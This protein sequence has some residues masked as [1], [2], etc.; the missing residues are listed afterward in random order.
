M[1]DEVSHST[2]H[3]TR[4]ILR[5]LSLTREKYE[6]VWRLCAHDEAMSE[7]TVLA[8][9]IT[10]ST[11]GNATLFLLFISTLIHLVCS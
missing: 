5:N 1:A 3:T 6:C 7:V 9:L 8:I 11:T 10:L 4:E 2:T